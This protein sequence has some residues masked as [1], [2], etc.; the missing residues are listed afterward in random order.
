MELVIRRAALALSAFLLVS[1]VATTRAGIE[2]TPAPVAR[3]SERLTPEALGAQLRSNAERASVA[4]RTTPKAVNTEIAP[5]QR[6]KVIDAYGKMPLSFI[7]NQG[8]ADE[9]VAYYIQSPGQSLYFTERGHTLHLTQGK[10]GDAKAHTVK[11]ELVDAAPERIA[12]LQAASGVVSYFKG[13]KEEWKTAIPTHSKIGYV[14][15]WPGIDLEYNGANGKLESIYT[16]APHAD[17]RQIKLRY[18]GHDTLSLDDEGNLVYSTIVGEIT[19][20]APVAWQD[21]GGKRSPVTTKFAL[22]DERTVTFQV[23]DYDREQPLIIDPVVYP[24]YAGYIGGG[25]DDFARGIAVDVS[26]NAYVVGYTSSTESTFPVVGGSDLT[27]NGGSY[28]VFIAKVNPSGTA[29]IYLTY[30]GGSGEDYGQAIAVDGAGNAYVTGRTNSTEATFPVTVGPDLTYNGGDNDAFVAKLNA[31]G[32]ALVYAGYIGGNNWDEAKGIA[33]D[34]AGNAYVAGAT[35]SSVATFPVTVGPN[36]TTNNGGFVAKV[37]S[38]GTALVYAGYTGSF[39][40]AVAVD[41]AGSA[42]VVGRIGSGLDATFPVTGPDLTF[43]GGSYDAFIAKVNPA[44]TAFVY[45]GYI[46]GSGYDEAN[47]VAVDTA[48]NAYVAGHT[49][50]SGGFG[51]PTS[52]YSYFSGGQYDYDAF[53]VKVNAAGTALDYFGYIGGSTYDYAFGISVDAAGSAYVVGATGGFPSWKPI[54]GPY[55]TGAGTFVAKVNPAGTDLDFLGYVGGAAGYGIA[56]DSAGSAYVAGVTGDGFPVKT[57]PGLVF[58]GSSSPYIPGDA[59]VAK[60]SV[61]KFSVNGSG[62][63]AGFVMTTGI[64]CSIDAGTPDAGCESDTIPFNSVLN[65]NA[66]PAAGSVFAGWSGDA[67]CANGIVTLD[68]SKICTATF[69]LAAGPPSLG[70]VAS[71]SD[72]D[73]DFGS[74]TVGTTA[75]PLTT[76]LTNTGTEAL[77][78]SGIT[79]AASY[80][81]THTC[82]GSLAAGDSCLIHVGF[83]PAALGTVYGNVSIT[84]N[85]AGSPHSVAL[86]G[87][88][89]DAPPPP[90]EPPAPPSPS[91]TPNVALFINNV[92]GGYLAS[93]GNPVKVTYTVAGCAGKEMFLVLRVAG[94]GENWWYVNTQGKLVQLPAILAQVQPYITSG[95]YDG[96]HTLFE[97]NVPPGDFEIYLGCDNVKD[98]HLNIDTLKHIDGVYGYAFGTVQ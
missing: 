3:A 62:N 87:T 57:G 13:P 75:G 64:D 93:F 43:N 58:A 97:G 41:V 47:A 20:S 50:S 24:A 72:I 89:V 30:L 42:Y 35:I 84:T 76:T 32:T 25:G 9:R 5:E 49:G 29:L 26:G 27:Y 60:I 91:P 63:G 4:A 77:T 18:S 31:A 95:P 14:Q 88:G 67:D 6:Q 19:E 39:A 82:P 70:P 34:A 33:V 37:K 83:T 56:L 16:V 40:N 65:L 45:A 21:I 55:L 11:V 85:A 73:L 79:T 48:G 22:L 38:D 90:P 80:S 94:W 8:Q 68:D 78:I 36:L 92:I 17:P 2:V 61:L 46:G 66:V 15:P 98:G 52:F 7:E 12:S 59:F 51:A 69:L 28:D 96:T 81:V 1:L 74:V 86:S 54:N 23:G 71:I 53:V 44:G 10:G